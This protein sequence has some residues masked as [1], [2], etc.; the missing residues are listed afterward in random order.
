[1][2]G[3]PVTVLIAEH[4]LDWL[5]EVVQAL[6]AGKTVHREGVA[7]RRDGSHLEAE[8]NA[9]PIMGADGRVRGT[10]LIVLDISE[11]R[12]TQRLLDRIVEHAPTSIAVKDLEG[13]YLL[14]GE[15]GAG[16]IGRRSEDIVG[17]TDHEVFAPSIA[18]RLVA[19]DKRVLASGRPLT[20][21]ETLRGPDGQVY[22]FVTTRFPLPGPDGQI[23]ALGLI[24]AD[25]SEIRR[26]ETDRAQL[27]ALVQAAPDAI[28]AR[29]RD[30]LITT[31]NP[32]AEVMFG[33]PAEHAIGRHYAELIVPAE[34]RDA[35]DA[36]VARGL[37]RAHD[38]GP[39]AAPARRRLAL[40]GADLDGAA[41]AARR[42]L[43]GHA[44]DD[45]RHHRP[46]AGR[47]RAARPGRAAGA[48]ERRPGALRLRR[49]PR[50]AGAA[51][52]DP[53]QRRG[54]DRGRPGAPRRRRARADGAHRH[55]RGAA[56]WSGARADGGRAGRDRAQRRG[57]PARWR[58]RCT[59]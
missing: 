1:M 56:Q 50:P 3:K 19:Q 52:L 23:E 43:A 42:L 30:G 35:F 48:L 26:A 29:D 57:A 6:A 21:E 47:E 41:E 28:V 39:H 59:R 54:G 22:V 49:Q 40:P 46:R 55:R 27:A 9:S 8:L 14:Y 31:W 24:A 18:A 20:T 12:R 17:R 33:L 32:G 25:V 13:R 36:L 37:R 15:R 44:V 38:H 7:L 45:P 2:I 4:Q 34:E 51:E 16:V 10:A 5:P 53:A 58:T 11:R